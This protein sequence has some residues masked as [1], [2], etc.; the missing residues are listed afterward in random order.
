MT[1]AQK[2]YLSKIKKIDRN[3]NNIKI[4]KYGLLSL[5]V[6]FGITLLVS[7]VLLIIGAFHLVDTIF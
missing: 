7:I 6:L 5:L 1:L 2:T 4:I 3:N